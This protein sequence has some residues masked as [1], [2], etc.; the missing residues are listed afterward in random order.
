M[1]YKSD[2]RETYEACCETH[3]VS[4][5]WYLLYVVECSI[6]RCS[7]RRTMARVKCETFSKVRECKL[8]RGNRLN[9]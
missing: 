4:F 3:D 7:S 6:G 5:A 8:N 1:G 2:K 9:N